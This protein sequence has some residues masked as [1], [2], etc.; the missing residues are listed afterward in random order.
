[1]LFGNKYLG[2]LVIYL[3]FSKKIVQLLSK[4]PRADIRSM[5]KLQSAQA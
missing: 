4:V 3:T 2:P 5:A 1:M